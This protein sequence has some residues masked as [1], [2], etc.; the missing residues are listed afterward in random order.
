MRKLPRIFSNGLKIVRFVN[1]DVK[2]DPFETEHI[3]EAR[4]DHQSSSKLA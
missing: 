4:R 2:S 3:L 1:V